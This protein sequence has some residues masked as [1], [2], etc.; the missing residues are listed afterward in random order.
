M[1]D[2]FQVL[3]LMAAPAAFLGTIGYFNRRAD[4]RCAELDA[5]T[6]LD[7]HGGS[8]ATVYAN[9]RIPAGK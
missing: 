8:P 5:A 2:L 9:P 1:A 4:R 3:V 7:H 6:S